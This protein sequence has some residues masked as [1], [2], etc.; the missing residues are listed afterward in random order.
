MLYALAPF[1]FVH[2]AISPQHLAISLPLILMV[3]S[4][5]NI[6]TCPSEN[7]FAVLLVVLVLALVRVASLYVLAAPPFASALFLAF[8]EVADEYLSC[9]P[10]VFSL[11]VRFSIKVLPSILISVGE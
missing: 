6:A 5:V 3:I 8:I 11:S 1:A 7:S 4:F 2:A 10:G 9:G